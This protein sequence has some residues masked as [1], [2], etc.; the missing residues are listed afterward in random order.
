MAFRVVL[1]L[2]LILQAILFHSGEKL[3]ADDLRILNIVLVEYLDK[4][5]EVGLNFETAIASQTTV[6]KK[7]VVESLQQIRQHHLADILSARQ[8]ENGVVAK[9][10][11]PR[12]SQL[13]P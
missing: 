3:S 13:T 1:S 12:Y 6:T 7:K 5:N 11:P 9:F 10:T 2:F 4:L 8:G